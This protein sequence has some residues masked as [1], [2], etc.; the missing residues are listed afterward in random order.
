MDGWMDNGCMDVWIIDVYMDV[1]MDVWMDY[2]IVIF[3]YLILLQGSCPVT[4]LCFN[5][6][7]GVTLI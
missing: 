5:K 4:F 2:I 3:Y 7:F 6:I 1:W